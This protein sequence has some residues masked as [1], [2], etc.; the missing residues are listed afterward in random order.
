[1]RRTLGTLPVAHRPIE[2]RC[3]EL[4]SEL[5]RRIANAFP[6]QGLDG[7]EPWKVFH[8]EEAF[9]TVAI[10]RD[11]LT[12]N[13]VV[14]VAFVGAADPEVLP[15]VEHSLRQ[16]ELAET[17]FV[18]HEAFGCGAPF[19][20]VPHL[21]HDEP[22]ASEFLERI[23]GGL[24]QLERLVPVAWSV[25][26]CAVMIHHHAL[27]EGDPHARAHAGPGAGEAAAAA[28]AVV[29][30]RTVASLHSVLDEWAAERSRCTDVSQELHWMR[31][32]RQTPQ[33]ARWLAGLRDTHAR[34]RVLVRIRRLSLGNPGDV[35]PVGAGVAE[36]RIDWGPGYR[37]YFV[38]HESAL[39]L[40]VGGDKRTQAADIETA[41]ELARQL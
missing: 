17:Q 34:A 13:H 29:S 12:P 38:A 2:S 10:T 14:R 23:L 37:V 26:R 22:L 40:L 19:L 3:S 4:H 20:V 32:I 11:L 15:A 7:R 25:Q 5:H 35:R 16:H 8:L 33:F 28:E 41:A 36:L 27:P 39:V 1:M 9:P 18:A 30:T 6:A 24:R 31:E 21:F